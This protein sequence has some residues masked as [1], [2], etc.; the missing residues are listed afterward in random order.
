MLKFGF[1]QSLIKNRFLFC[2]VFINLVFSCH[3][4]NKETIETS[5]TNSENKT[6]LKLVEKSIPEKEE[7]TI[8]LS[9]YN[10]LALIEIKDSKQKDVFKKYGIEFGGVCYSCDLAIFKINDKSFEIASLCNEKDFHSYQKFSYE[11]TDNN[12]KS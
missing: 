5:P 6:E 7:I 11:K 10:K 4:N 2:T 12:L 1:N 9:D 8:N 3:K